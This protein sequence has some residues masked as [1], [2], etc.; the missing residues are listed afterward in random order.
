MTVH[1]STHYSPFEIV[2]GFN[3]LIPLDLLP[4]PIHEHVNLDGAKKADFARKL[5]ETVSQ[6]IEKRNQQM[7]NQRNKGRIKVV[8]E[9]GKWVWLHLRKERFPKKRHSKLQPRGNSPF[10]VVARVND[11]AYKLDLPGEYN[12]SVTFNIFDL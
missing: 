9:P 8:F 3:P 10:Q 11:N 4:L 7:A 6:N 12:V 1:S 2:Y 5:H